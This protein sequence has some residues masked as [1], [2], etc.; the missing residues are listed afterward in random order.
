[1][2]TPKPR[3]QKAARRLHGPLAETPDAEIDDYGDH[4]DY[5]Q[6]GDGL[7]R[8]MA[9]VRAAYGDAT[10]ECDV[11]RGGEWIEDGAVLPVVAL[12]HLECPRGKERSDEPQKAASRWREALLLALGTVALMVGI[13]AWVAFFKAMEWLANG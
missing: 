3:S 10:W 6:D 12:H 2:T 1:M 13:A 4:P 9:T 7:A 11:C 5:P 8:A